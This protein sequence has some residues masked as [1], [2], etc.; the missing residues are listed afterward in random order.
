MGVTTGSITY[1]GDFSLANAA[2]FKGSAVSADGFQES[3]TFGTLANQFNRSTILEIDL[4][5]S[6]T[7]V[8]DLQAALMENNVAL[9]L[10]EDRHIS[11]I[12]DKTNLGRITI[13][14]DATDGWT[15]LLQLGSV[16]NLEPAARVVM[17]CPQDGKYAVSGSDKELLLTNTDGSNNNKI[18]IVI[19]GTNA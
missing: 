11:F 17:N 10:V 16:L 15:A 6:A 7:Q 13:E 19:A 2:P 1:S 4:A 18:T 12:A 8:V 14:P 9:G 3:W 5:P